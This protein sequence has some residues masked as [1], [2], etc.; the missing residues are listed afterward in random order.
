MKI[1][2]TVVL[3]NKLTGRYF[4]QANIRKCI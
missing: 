2:A 3:H 4:L 1:H